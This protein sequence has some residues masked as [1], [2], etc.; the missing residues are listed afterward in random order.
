MLPAV[1]RRADGLALMT[2][3]QFLMNEPVHG[4]GLVENADTAKRFQSD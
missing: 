2:S 3:R 1:Q 4:C